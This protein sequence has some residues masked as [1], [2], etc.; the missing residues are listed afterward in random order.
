MEPPPQTADRSIRHKVIHGFAWLGSAKLVAQIG[1]WAATLI[2]ARI[3]DPADYG[4]VAIAG[5]FLGLA[6][7]LVEMGVT[8]G[9]LRI[10]V[11]LEDPEDLREDL[12][13]ALSAAGF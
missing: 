5:V 10:N 1:S 9:L 13:R 2:V 7:M 11:G 12:D 4:L 6:D 8:E 3:L